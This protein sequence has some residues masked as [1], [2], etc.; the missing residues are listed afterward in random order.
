M[1]RM[2]RLIRKPVSI[3]NETGPLIKEVH[4]G[5]GP[6]M[7]RAQWT[8]IQLDKVSDADEERRRDDGWKEIPL[9]SC[10]PALKTRSHAK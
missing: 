8:S 1:E 6:P 2:E 5:V 7:L 9:V 3:G 10:Q 4:V